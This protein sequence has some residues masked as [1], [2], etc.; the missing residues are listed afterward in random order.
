MILESFNHIGYFFDFSLYC[1]ADPLNDQ[2]RCLVQGF[3]A[4]SI[5]EIFLYPPCPAYF[6]ICRGY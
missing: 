5:P 4:G 2:G 6:V 1:I 3:T